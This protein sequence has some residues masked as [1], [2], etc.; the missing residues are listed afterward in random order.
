MNRADKIKQSYLKSFTK[1]GVSLK[2]L[3]WANTSAA[4]IRYLQLIDE[5]IEFSGKDIL[6]VGCGFGGIL[7][8][9]KKKAQSFNYLGV[10]LV[11]Q[12]IAEARKNNPKYIFKVMDYYGKPLK[13]KFDIILSSGTLNANTSSPMKYRYSAIKTMWEHTSFVLAFNM[14]G[15]HP[16]PKNRK[17]SRI[18]YA[19]SMEVLKYCLALSPKVVFK[20]HYSPK[21]IDFTIIMFR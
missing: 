3:Q 2:A 21:N 20:Q 11:P 5:N 10:D 1:H 7:E 8:I 6:D 19:D 4:K 15:Y 17:E 16:Q 12:F 18:F 14:A 9:I 13:R